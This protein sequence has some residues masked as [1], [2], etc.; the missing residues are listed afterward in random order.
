MG[1]HCLWYMNNPSNHFH[2]ENDCLIWTI[3]R[4]GK[5]LSVRNLKLLSELERN[6]SS[7]TIFELKN[8]CPS[9]DNTSILP[10]NLGVISSFFNKEFV[11]TSSSL[12][13]QTL[14]SWTE[15]LPKCLLIFSSVEICIGELLSPLW[16]SSQIM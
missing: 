12:S 7:W 8:G 10:P 3:F 11:C 9:I 4:T 1:N 16:T 14:S 13:M 2:Y 5:C 6:C 15:A